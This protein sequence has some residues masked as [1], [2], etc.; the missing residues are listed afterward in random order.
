M[1]HLPIICFSF[2]NGDLGGIIPCITEHSYF[3][4]TKEG[5][6]LQKVSNLAFSFVLEVKFCHNRLRK[7]LSFGEINTFQK[8]ASIYLEKCWPS[9]PEIHGRGALS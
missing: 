8:T 5:C 9:V 3:R 2:I 6:L 4:N 7:I 1:Y